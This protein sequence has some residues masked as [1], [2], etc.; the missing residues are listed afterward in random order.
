M[1]QEHC[2]FM[3][4]NGNGRC[5]APCS[6]ANVIEGTDCIGNTGATFDGPFH[7]EVRVAMQWFNWIERVIDYKPDVNENCTWGKSKT[8]TSHTAASLKAFN[9]KHGVKP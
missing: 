2:A 7:D 9:L 3:K 4:D 6:K 1:R 8:A 5:I